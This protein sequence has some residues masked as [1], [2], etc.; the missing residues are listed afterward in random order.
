MTTNKA[1]LT[2]YFHDRRPL[3]DLVEDLRRLAPLELRGSI[4]RSTVTEA[5]VRLAVEDLQ[6]NGRQSG[7]VQDMVTLPAREVEP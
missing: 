2:I 4:T 3:D 1:R 7:I 6:V 5:A